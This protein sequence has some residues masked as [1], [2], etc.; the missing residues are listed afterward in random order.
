MPVIIEEVVAEIQD[1]V[2]LPGESSPDEA[3]QPLTQSEREVVAA[4]ERIQERQQRLRI[5]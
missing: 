5:D 2:T 1:P 4:L 3:Q